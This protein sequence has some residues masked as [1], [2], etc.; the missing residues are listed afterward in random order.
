MLGGGGGVG[1]NP[2][3]HQSK[4]PFLREAERHCAVLLLSFRVPSNAC[5][6]FFLSRLPKVLGA[7]AYFFGRAVKA[8]RW[9]FF[10]QGVTGFLAFPVKGCNLHWWF[11]WKLS[12]LEVPK[13]EMEETRS[14]LVRRCM[15]PAF[16]HWS[17]LT[18]G[19]PGSGPK[20][21]LLLVN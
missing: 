14:G 3:S 10:W 2:L 21:V 20:A 9:V 15:W 13:R 11:P 12:L 5:G 18:D 6:H 1:V 17:L 19:C 8:P 16:S 4:P 7:R